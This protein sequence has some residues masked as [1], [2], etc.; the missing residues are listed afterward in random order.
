MAGGD[1]VYT[2]EVPLNVTRLAGLTTTIIGSV[3][4]GGRD[5]DTRGIV[6]GDSETWRTIP[7]ALVSQGGFDVNRIRLMIGDNSLVG[8]IVMGDQTL[9]HPIHQLVKNQVDISPIKDQL[10]DGKDI[11]GVLSEFWTQVRSN[12]TKN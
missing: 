9:S 5:D 10:V 1:V 7:D 3:S 4:T 6:R 11:S 12:Q 8:A 2:K